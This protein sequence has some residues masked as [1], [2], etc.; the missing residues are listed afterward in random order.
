M[1]PGLQSTFQCIPKVIRGLRSRLCAGYWSSS[2]SNSS[3]HVFMELTLGTA[4]HCHSGT[5]KAPNCCHKLVSIELSKIYPL[6]EQM[7]PNPEKPLSLH[8]YGSMHSHRI[9][10]SEKRVIQCSREYVSIAQESSVL[11]ATSSNTWP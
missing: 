9:R 11:Y 4:A 8:N 6:V 2:T 10:L 5:E 3:N 7:S 1:R